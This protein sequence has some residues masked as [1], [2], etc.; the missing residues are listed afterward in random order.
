V[1]FSLV[2]QLVKAICAVRRDEALY[3]VMLRDL[4]Q[5]GQV[6][7]RRKYRYLALAY[8]MFLGGLALTLAVFLFENIA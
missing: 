3:R 2:M 6:L 5:N 7:H 4:Y 1:V 8:R